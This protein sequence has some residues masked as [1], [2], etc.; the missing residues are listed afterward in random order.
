MD[1]N[2]ACMQALEQELRCWRLLVACGTVRRLS[3]I[4]MVS[5]ARFGAYLGLSVADDQLAE[6]PLVCAALRTFPPERSVQFRV[7]VLSFASDGSLTNSPYQLRPD[8]IQEIRR[9][10]ERLNSA[11]LTFVG[12]PDLDH[13]LVWER[14]SID[15]RIDSADQVGGKQMSESAPEGDGERMLRAWIEDSA[16][17]LGR[18]EMNARRLDEGLPPWSVLWPYGQGLKPQLPNLTLERRETTFVQSSQILMEGLTLLV[19]YKHEDRSSSGRGLNVPLRFLAEKAAKFPRSL[20]VMDSLEPFMKDEHTDEINWFVREWDANFCQPLWNL[21][22]EHPGSRVTFLFPS[23]TGDPGLSLTVHGPLRSDSN[24][25]CDARLL[26]DRNIPIVH[27][28]EASLEAFIC[29]S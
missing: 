2:A 10:G 8:E 13:G 26:D 3:P 5:V 9:V 11:A 25:P 7:G 1:R 27:L 17:L 23:L 29:E 6:G 15:L 28:H 24:Q 16:D 4:D 21:L 20:T 14:G 19:G 18:T 22:Q 12:G